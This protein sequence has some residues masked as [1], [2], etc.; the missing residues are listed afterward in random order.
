MEQKCAG[1]RYMYMLCLFSI[2]VIRLQ[3]V[4][5]C[6][7]SLKELIPRLHPALWEESGNKA[8]EI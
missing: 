6:I 1:H 2:L 4:I 7:L 3:Q 5:G 8:R